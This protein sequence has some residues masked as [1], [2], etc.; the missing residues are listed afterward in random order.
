MDKI[1]TLKGLS[2]YI[3]S[4]KT[5]KNINKDIQKIYNQFGYGYDEKNDAELLLSLQEYNQS[6]EYP[7][8]ATGQS[9]YFNEQIDENGLTV[10]EM[11]QQDIEDAEFISR[12]FNI[13]T[14]FKNNNLPMIYT[15][16]LGTTEFNYATQSFPAVIFE[17]VFQCSPNHILPI[18]PLVGEKEPDFY[19]R[20]L[21]YQIKNMPMFNKEKEQEVLFRSKRLIEHFCKNKNRVYLIRINDVLQTKASFGD[22]CGLRDRTLS[23]SEIVDKIKFL[24]SFKELMGK[25]NISRDTMYFNPNM[26]SEYGIALYGSIPK[27]KLKYI[28]VERTYQV[29]QKKALDMGLHLGDEIPFGYKEEI[30]R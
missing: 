13:N 30:S 22:V 8:L 24:D 19:L 3:K 1:Q 4:L 15:T 14:N 12:S 5:T 27:E 26:T 20:L 17:D 29:M 16:L 10:L 11:K 6:Q 7:L 21:K 18:R 28:E 23:N 2:N 25:Y 9:G